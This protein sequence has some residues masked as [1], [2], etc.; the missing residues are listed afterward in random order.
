MTDRVGEDRCCPKCK[1]PA[2]IKNV[3]RD[4]RHDVLVACVRALKRKLVTDPLTPLSFEQPSVGSQTFKLPDAASFRSH[5][6]QASLATDASRSKANEADEADDTSD[7][8]AK[9]TPETV[10]NAQVPSNPP[11]RTYMSAS[12]AREALD[13]SSQNSQNSYDDGA[14][15]LAMLDSEGVPED[16][17]AHNTNIRDEP[18]PATLSKNSTHTLSNGTN[19]LSRGIPSLQQNEPGDPGDQTESAVIHTAIR[20]PVDAG[21]EDKDEDED[22]GVNQSKSESESGNEDEDDS[23]Q[24]PIS[25]SQ[26]PHSYNDVYGS[27]HSVDDTNTIESS[28][29]T[30]NEPDENTNDNPIW[31]PFFY[32]PRKPS[33]QRHLTSARDAQKR[34][35]LMNRP[36]SASWLCPFC[37]FKNDVCNERCA[38]CRKNRED[39]AK[40]DMPRHVEATLLPTMDTYSLPASVPTPEW[41][42]DMTPDLY[43]VHVLF[44]HVD[45]VK[46]LEVCNWPTC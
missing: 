22:E 12:A 33:S 24:N 11:E 38:V 34:R 2:I 23:I 8:T 35:R 32:I 9:R 29:G 31:D 26:P 4:P 1:L 17:D 18:I 44:T 10:Q 42:E 16:A 46:R 3:R 37:Q 40:A 43:P 25:A 39:H 19:P 13:H 21:N 14:L 28:A 41:E 30:E 45:E 36:P 7:E 15:L 5:V 20:M 6:Q 27:L